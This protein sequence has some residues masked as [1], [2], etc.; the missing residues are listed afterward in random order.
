MLT[1]MALAL[2]AFAWWYAALVPLRLWQARA[3]ARYDRAAATWL[4]VRDAD[5]ATRELTAGHARDPSTLAA[6]VLA[7]AEATGIAVSR[8]RQDARG[9]LALEVDATDAPA[10]L[11]W[12]DLLQRQHGV[13]VERLRVEK[14]DGRLR[15]ALSVRPAR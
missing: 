7:A 6:G 5:A 8:Q 11:A 13:A 3:Q 15:V 1:V 9:R 12:L 10:L 14:R 4:A 2:A